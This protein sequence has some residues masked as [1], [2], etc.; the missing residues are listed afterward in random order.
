MMHDQNVKSSVN[1]DYCLECDKQPEFIKIVDTTDELGDE[2]A[3]ELYSCPCGEFTYL[4]PVV[5][6]D[7]FSEFGEV[8]W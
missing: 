4:M 2:V 3:A 1:P 7:G 6:D 8:E 5:D